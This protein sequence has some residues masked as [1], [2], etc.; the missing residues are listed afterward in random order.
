VLGKKTDIL[1][2]IFIILDRISSI[3]YSHYCLRLTEHL[4]VKRKISRVGGFFF[5]YITLCD[6]IFAVVLT[7][8]AM[9]V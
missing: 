1:F 6:L 4:K 3:M 9:Y 5:L 7:R 8:Q 2:W